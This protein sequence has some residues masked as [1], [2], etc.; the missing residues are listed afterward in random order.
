VK[1]VEFLSREN[2]VVDLLPAHNAAVGM[3]ALWRS[4][5]ARRMLRSVAKQSLERHRE[6]Q[7]RNA[8]AHARRGWLW[9][10]VGGR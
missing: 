3:Q 10:L 7:Q 9:A 8:A 1:H 2:G 6:E 4:F 5:R